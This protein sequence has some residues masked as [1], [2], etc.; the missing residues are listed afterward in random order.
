MVP[1]Y[2]IDLSQTRCSRRLIV[3][4]NF[5]FIRV[6]FTL[7]NTFLNGINDFIRIWASHVTVRS[8]VPAEN[9]DWT[10]V[11]ILAT[12]FET[13]FVTSGAS[14]S[15]THDGSIA[16]VEDY[17]TRVMSPGVLPVIGRIKSL[18][19]R[20]MG[21]LFSQSLF[22]FSVVVPVIQAASDILWLVGMASEGSGSPAYL[23]I[24]FTQTA[25]GEAWTQCSRLSLAG[26]SSVLSNYTRKKSH[27][28]W[29]SRL[30]FWM[31]AVTL[32]VQAK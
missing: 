29:F 28:S 27:V 30:C 17:E 16:V 32:Y 3:S 2:S 4:K 10:P 14:A 31:F 9:R 20:I 23:Q 22:S 19:L 8:T 7:N 25:E 5:N 21:L 11:K 12:F 6:S 24:S 13:R 26:L 18:L 15:N 1:N